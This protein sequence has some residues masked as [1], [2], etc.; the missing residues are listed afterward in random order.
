VQ[1]PAGSAYAASPELLNIVSGSIGQVMLGAV[2]STH[3]KAPVSAGGF[4]S[5]GSV[6]GAGVLG[7]GWEFPDAVMAN[8]SAYVSASSQEDSIKVGGVVEPY[9]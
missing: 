2:S 7:T 8:G 6:S 5:I 3:I 4:A 1:D 9:T